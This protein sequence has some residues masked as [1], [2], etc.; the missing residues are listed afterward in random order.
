M[1]LINDFFKIDV[2]TDINT[3]VYNKLHVKKG[4]RIKF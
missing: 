1:L 2:L 4:V 3:Y